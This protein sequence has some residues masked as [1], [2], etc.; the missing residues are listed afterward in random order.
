MQLVSD[1]KQVM[2]IFTTVII[3]KIKR[4]NS[5]VKLFNNKFCVLE[6]KKKRRNRK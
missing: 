3:E 4:E 1:H 5:K 2:S 6:K